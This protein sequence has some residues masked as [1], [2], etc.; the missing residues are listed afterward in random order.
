MC[1]YVR[2]CLRQSAVLNVRSALF[3]NISAV[4]ELLRQ[5][6]TNSAES[7][8]EVR[9]SRC[10]QCGGQVMKDQS[11]RVGG[12]VVLSLSHS[13]THS[14]TYSKRPPSFQTTSLSKRFLTHQHTKRPLS[15]EATSLPLET[16]SVLSL[17]E[18]T[19][20][21]CNGFSL[22][23]GPTFLS[24]YLSFRSIYLSFS[25]L[26]RSYFSR[27]YFLKFLKLSRISRKQ[28]LLTTSFLLL[29]CVGRWLWFRSH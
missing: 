1:M 8:V 19:S 21:C 10:V 29:V 2:T 12:F 13:L 26:S 18:T 14:L 22:L 17:W 24:V 11:L 6:D 7:G 20:L 4:E 15:L 5:S 23:F 25:K 28:R 3:K 9:L 16:N 27:S